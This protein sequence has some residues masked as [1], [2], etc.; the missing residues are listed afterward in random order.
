MQL[1]GDVIVPEGITLTVL[2]GT[3][4]RFPALTDAAFGGD[5]P[6][7]SEIIVRGSLI[8]Q[9]TE[10]QPIVFTSDALHPAK[11][12]WGGV[13]GAGTLRLRYMQ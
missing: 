4:L 6:Y 5:N 1:D 2:P 8:A 7:K 9:G 13:R 3:M 10:E 12:D 11:G